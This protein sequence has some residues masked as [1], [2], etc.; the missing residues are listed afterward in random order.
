[1]LWIALLVCPPWHAPAQS[2]GDSLLIADFESGVRGWRTNDGLAEQRGEPT[3]PGIYAVSP[4]A[5]EGGGGQAALVEFGAGQQTWASVT[6][7]VDGSAWADRGCTGVSLWLRGDGGGHEVDIVLRSYL[8]VGEK[9]TDSSYIRTVS[10]TS[11]EWFSLGAPFSSFRNAAGEPIDGKHLRAVKLLQFVKTGTWRPLRFTVDQ[12]RAV[13]LPAPAEPRPVAGTRILDFDAGGRECRLQ[14]GLCF[15]SQAMQQLRDAGFAAK[16]KGSLALLGRPAVRV[17]LSDFY[18]LD[19]EQVNTIGLQEALSW[20]RSCGCDPLLCLD[21]PLPVSGVSPEKGWRD[22]GTLC[23][24][25]AGLRRAEPGVHYYEIGSEPL[26]AGHFRTVEA[27][28][29]AYNALAAQVLLADPR[30]QVGG[31]GFA[32]AWDENLRYFVEHA[33]TLHFLSFHFYGAHSPVAGDE[34]LF[35]VACR[36]QAE[37][38]PH[39]VGPAAIRQMVEGRRGADV[40]VWITE[41]ALNSA[42]EANGRAR[43]GRVQTTYG[44]AWLGAFSLAVAPYV[45]RVLWFKAF[46]HGWGLLTD[47][48][49]ATAAFT[50]AVLLGRS[51]PAGAITGEPIRVGASG[52]AAA[53][54]TTQGRYVIVAHAGESLTAELRLQGTPPVRPVRI[55]RIDPASPLAG[56]EPMAPSPAQRLTLPGPGV[57]VIEA[58]HKP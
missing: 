11:A 52:I 31:M 6:V 12:I 40:E 10:L 48:G 43:D 5:P 44:A 30:G 57:A 36:G 13:K 15:G 33:R 24:R 41:C 16:V 8:K 22:F 54:S 50:A 3:I 55:R 53:V 32:S 56:F 1:M 47:D 9:T 38:L 51:L 23:A 27:A 28:T 39:Q 58:P 26:L 7:S 49:E 20:I 34:E 45:D 18:L 42:R 25:L 35:D 17:R 19:L 29:S 2:Q 21:R 14:H 46:G 4:G 37:D